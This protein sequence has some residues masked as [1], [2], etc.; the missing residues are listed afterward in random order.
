MLRINLLPAYIGE[1]RKTRLAIAG[2]SA[3]ALAVTGGMLF[4]WS[5]QK[6]AVEKREAE[7]A[8]MERQAQA[9]TELQNQASSIRSGILPITNKVSFIEQVRFYNT[10]RPKIFRQAARYTTNNVEYSAMSVQQQTLSISA[11]AP[12]TSDIGR[13]LIT[14]F[15]NP[16]LS[17]VSVA[18]VPGWGGQGGGGGGGYGGG[19]VP[20]GSGYGGSG[21]SGP[22]AAGIASGGAGGGYGGGGGGYGGGGGF[23]PGGAGQPQNRRGFPFSVTA[24]LIQPVTPPTPPSA[25]GGAA[26]GGGVGQG[27]GGYGG[28]GAYGAGPAA[29]AYGGGGGRGGAMAE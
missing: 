9:V 1:K 10:L 8:D 22:T 19:G 13:F 27:F 4:A 11:F 3:L 18:G 2:A 25:G 15:G 20:G 7:A 6:Q 26:G 21:G 29:G 12:K 23:N 24:T 5:V 28:G 14:M 17:A 16:D